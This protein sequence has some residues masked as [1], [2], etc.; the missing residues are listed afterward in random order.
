MTSIFDITHRLNISLTPHNTLIT[1]VLLSHTH[2]KENKEQP[3][4]KTH[5]TQEISAIRTMGS[6]RL[7]SPKSSEDPSQI[8]SLHIKIEDNNSHPIWLTTFAIHTKGSFF[9]TQTWPFLDHDRTCKLLADWLKPRRSLCIALNRA[10][11]LPRDGARGK[12]RVWQSCHVSAS[13]LAIIR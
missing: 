8:L 9:F 7:T 2:V 12:R 4:I 3:H 6:Q 10:P 13:R 5:N 1:H 11:C